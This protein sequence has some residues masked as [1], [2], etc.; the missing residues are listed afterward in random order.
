MRAGMLVLAFGL[1][2]L[3]AGGY[4]T[5]A[6]SAAPPPAPLEV[7]AVDYEYVMPSV[8]KGGVVAM[9]FRNRGKE[10]HEF[11]FGRIDKG[12]TLVQAVRAF[13]QHKEAPWIH[14][15]GGPGLLTPGAEIR[16]TRKL[17]P[18]AY[19]FIDAVPNT[20]GV[21]HYKLGMA[22]SLTIAGDSGAQLP[23]ADAVITAEKK[24]FAVPQLYGG[25]QTIELRNRAGSGRG[26][27]LVTLNPGKTTAEAKRW[28]NSIDATGKL[29]S[30]P[31][32]MTF[33]GAM[34]T[35]PSGT[36]VYLTINLQAGRRYHL[37]DDESGVKAD[38]TPR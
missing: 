16:I 21:P 4:G 38:F 36:S 7:D 9:R 8:A 3:A 18:G 5:V 2:A 19:F 17:R 34:Q 10:L 37:S 15:L 29:P 1:S 6:R 13:D 20:K 28:A 33:L 22:R 14:D 35:I 12:H 30:G 11:A 25:L 31:T 23:K 32:P 27:Q 24:R 26:F